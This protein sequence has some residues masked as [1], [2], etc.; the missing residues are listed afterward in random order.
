MSA[1]RPVTQFAVTVTVPTCHNL[2]HTT[3][4]KIAPLQIEPEILIPSKK[5]PQSIQ[6][7]KSVRL[8]C[9]RPPVR[10]SAVLHDPAVVDGFALGLGPDE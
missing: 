3:E 2:I 5:M 7:Q 6:Q 4:R 8:G 1:Q 10:V 9:R